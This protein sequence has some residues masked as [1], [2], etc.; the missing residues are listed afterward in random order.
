MLFLRCFFLDKHLKLARVE[1]DDVQ[2]KDDMLIEDLRKKLDTMQNILKLK[3]KE[4]SL[5]ILIAGVM[6]I[7][8]FIKFFYNNKL[9]KCFAS[10]NV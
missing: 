2:Q 7:I 1:I 9:S 5:K 10:R 3:E 4:R 8:P 6:R